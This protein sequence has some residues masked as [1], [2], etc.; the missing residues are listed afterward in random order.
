MGPQ[1]VLTEPIA[2][3]SGSTSVGDPC[4]RSEQAGG[5]A[6]TLILSPKASTLMVPDLHKFG[7]LFLF[8]ASAPLSPPLLALYRSS[9]IRFGAV[10][11][12]RA[13]FAIASP[14]RVIPL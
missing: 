8:R 3:T 6:I 5:I 9:T 12:P 2:T 11:L 13:L 1:K 7:G 10:A 14:D 4:E